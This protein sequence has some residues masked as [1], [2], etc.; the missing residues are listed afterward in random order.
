MKK[1]VF[2]LLLIVGFS[3]LYSQVPQKMSYQAVIRDASNQLVVNQIIG[4]E[5]SIMQYSP[6]GLPVYLETHR[7]TTNANGLISL[8]I[9]TGT[10]CI[11]CA[12]QNIDWSAGPYYLKMGTTF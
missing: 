2:F 1:T 11:G 10:P 12:F 3:A 9:G 8:E 5:I 6:N 4:I 7:P